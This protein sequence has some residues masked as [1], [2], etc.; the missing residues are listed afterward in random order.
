MAPQEDYKAPCHTEGFELIDPGTLRWDELLVRDTFW[1]EDAEVILAIPICEG[2]QDWPAWHFDANALAGNE[3]LTGGPSLISSQCWLQNSQP[4]K[5]KL[6][7]TSHHRLERARGT[8]QQQQ[9][10][11]PASRTSHL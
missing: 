5:P 9:Q 10:L 4:N 8:L 1:P 2:V 3:W 7:R 11:Q 6:P